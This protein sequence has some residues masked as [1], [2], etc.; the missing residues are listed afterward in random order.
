MTDSYYIFAIAEWLERCG[1]RVNLYAFDLPATTGGRYVNET[2]EIFMNVCYARDALL[3]LAHE[4]GHWLGYLID[5]K[6]H[7]YQREWQAFVYG[8]H[9][10]RWFDAPVTRAEWLEDCRKSYYYRLKY[11]LEGTY[12]MPYVRSA[13]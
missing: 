7:V 6:P 4:A 8:W 13:V 9:V 5:E 3:T 11:T 12:A 10:L 1:V 2:R